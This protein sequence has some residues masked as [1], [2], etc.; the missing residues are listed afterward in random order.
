MPTYRDEAVVLRTHTLGEADRVINL[1]T[2]DHGK[3]R[4]IGRGVRRTSSK[5]GARLEPGN[6]V[7]VQ[8]AIGRGSLDIVA[9]TEGVHLFDFA[10]DYPKFTAAQ[11]ILE[12]ADKVVQED[13]SPAHRHYRLLLGALLALDRGEQPS[14]LIV[15]SYLL[16]ALAIGG[17][18]MAI[19]SCAS[20]S[21]AQD[22]GWFAAA[23]GG[24]LCD[25]CHP[26]A[27]SRV[28]A[29]LLM[30]LA[31]LQTGDWAATKVSTSLR[32]RAGAMIVTFAQWQLDCALKSLACLIRD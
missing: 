14:E 16:R 28:E 13:R 27:A 23:M 4:A 17:Y 2:R 20:C 29:E 31:A 5:F 3:V 24:V 32:R 26:V 18:A 9:Q 25:G 10:A 6:H 22:Q 30:Y 11:V 7:D 19:S 15:D 8:F 12:A 21:T 1:L